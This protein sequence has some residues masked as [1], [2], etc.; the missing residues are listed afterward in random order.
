MLTATP[1][2]NGIEDLRWILC[3]LENSSWLALPLP[4]D[5]FGYTHNFDDHWVTDRSNVS[6]T[7]RS[8]VFTPVANPY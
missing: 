2:V 4:P 6:G 7:E 8:A 1:L 5:T 3:F